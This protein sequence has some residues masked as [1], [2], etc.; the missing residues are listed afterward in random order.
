M[1]VRQRVS[2]DKVSVMLK[3]RLDEGFVVR[4]TMLC[5]WIGVVSGVWAG[6]GIS[7]WVLVGWMSMINVG[8][9]RY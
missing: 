2:G 9:L 4:E 8:V 3:L 6:A 7:V 5:G 1:D